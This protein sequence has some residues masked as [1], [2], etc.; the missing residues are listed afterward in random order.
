M[1]AS[2]VEKGEPHGGSL[3]TIYQHGEEISRARPGDVAY[4][5]PGSYTFTSQPNADN[6]LSLDETLDHGERKE[7]VFE[8]VQT[9]RVTINMVPSGSDERMRAGARAAPGRRAALQGE[10]T[11][12][13][14]PPAPTI[15]C[16]R[17]TS[18]RGPT[19]D[20]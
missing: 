12:H 9:V 2:F 18:L 17:S 5:E 20:W 13:G 1:V 6:E 16:C 15:W 11:R 7:L 19:R 3:V 4:L 8:L 14:A 10:P